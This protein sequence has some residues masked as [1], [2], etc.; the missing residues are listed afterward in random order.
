MAPQ[1]DCAQLQKSECLISNPGKTLGPFGLCCT[2]HERASCEELPQEEVPPM[3]HH[4]IVKRLHWVLPTVLLL[5]CS[6]LN[7]LHS[8]RRA[9]ACTEFRFLE[10]GVHGKH[11]P[12]KAQASGILDRACLH[13]TCQLYQVCHGPW[14]DTH[15]QEPGSVKEFALHDSCRFIPHSESCKVGL[16]STLYMWWCTRLISHNA[17]ISPD[18]LCMNN[19][20]PLY[21]S[22]SCWHISEG[23]QKPSS[24][25]L[26]AP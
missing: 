11:R 14:E 10:T 17:C 12:C 16:V 9:L 4:H 24:Q 1:D 5:S 22:H 6:T 15:P 18:L 3:I 2:L 25:S 23:C 8:S 13:A 20:R 19:A 21:V 7:C 26:L